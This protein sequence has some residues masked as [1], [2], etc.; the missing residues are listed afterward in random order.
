[1]TGPL[2]PRKVSPHVRAELEIAIAVARERL[3]EAHAAQLLELIHGADGQLTPRRA[4]EIYARLHHLGPD[5]A[6][7]VGNKV[8]ASL[9]QF[10]EVAGPL[11]APG[12][13]GEGGDAGDPLTLFG[14]I[15]RRLRG[16]TN[17]ELRRKVELLT[18]RAEVA[19]MRVHVENVLRLLTAFGEEISVAQLVDAY[20][21]ILEVRKSVAE[22]VYFFTLDRMASP[23][24]G[25]SDRNGA[26]NGAVPAIGEH[27]LRVIS[28]PR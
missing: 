5:M 15:R 13:G 10:R 26:W 21:Q 1:M 11:P 24:S 25:R 28:N 17:L 16:R 7:N 12:R 19:L 9:G 4:T 14:Q 18:G 6:R 23:L 27:T 2:D 8:L 3:Q 22:M 20:A